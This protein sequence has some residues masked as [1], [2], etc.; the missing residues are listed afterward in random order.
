MTQEI[1]L[2]RAFAT[3]EVAEVKGAAVTIEGFGPRLWNI[4]RANNEEYNKLFMKL[5]AEKQALIDDRSSEAAQARADQAAKDVVLECWAKTILV[6]WEGEVTFNGEKLTYSAENAKKLLAVNEL[7][8][9]FAAKANDFATYRIFKDD[10]E[11][12]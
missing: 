12:N 2:F 7:F 9:R 1:D 11:K 3:D 8:K 10:K 6:G 4:A 5:Y